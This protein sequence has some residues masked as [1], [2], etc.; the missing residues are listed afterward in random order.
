MMR[1]G[2]G[3]DAIAAACLW[4]KEI[5]APARCGAATKPAMLDMSLAGDVYCHQMVTIYAEKQIADKANSQVP[6]KRG[7]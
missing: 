4:L 3:A 7:S 6:R 5:P 1:I 2:Y